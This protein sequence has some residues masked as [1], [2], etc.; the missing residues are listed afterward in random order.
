MSIVPKHSS[1][2]AFIRR[3]H[4]GAI[5][6]QRRRSDARVLPGAWDVVGGKIEPRESTTQALA[7][8]VWEETGWVVDT[9]LSE[10]APHSYQLDGREWIEFCFLVEVTGV[11]NAPKLETDRYIEHQWFSSEIELR[12]VDVD[13]TALGYGSYIHAIAAEAL[14]ASKAVER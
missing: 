7:R 14:V 3:P 10:L 8:E 11:L 13:N 5:L 2:A 4:D 6:L 12:R 9:I 1:V